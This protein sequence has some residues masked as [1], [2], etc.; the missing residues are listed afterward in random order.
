[1]GRGQ[2][3]FFA[4]LLFCFFHRDR[5]KWQVLLCTHSAAYTHILRWCIAF[6]LA[7]SLSSYI[8]FSSLS[9]AICWKCALHS[10]ETITEKHSYPTL[11]I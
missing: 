10:F 7:L 9:S 2:V 5:S 11:N 3:F 1:L 6:S 4:F 8:S